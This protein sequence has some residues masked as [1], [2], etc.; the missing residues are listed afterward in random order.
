MY[1]KGHLH[2]RRFWGNSMNAVKPQI[3]IAVS[4]YVLM[5]IA[6]KQTKPTLSLHSILTSYRSLPSKKIP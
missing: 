4:V 1:I 3:R 2:L 5:A 6:K